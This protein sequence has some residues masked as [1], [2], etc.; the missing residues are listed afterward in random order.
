MQS[1]DVIENSDDFLQTLLI[2]STESEK[3]QTVQ[4]VH[5]FS[6]KLPNCN[7]INFRCQHK[8]E[9]DKKRPLHYSR[10]GSFCSKIGKMYLH[11]FFF[12]QECLEH[13]P[14]SYFCLI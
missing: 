12:T 14:F 13:D 9:Q 10:L 8:I 1:R 11:M 4:H 3:L 2:H 7:L 6:A 5:Y